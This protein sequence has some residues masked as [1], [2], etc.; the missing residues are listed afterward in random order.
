MSKNVL[1]SEMK[2]HRKVFIE[3]VRTDYDKR[4]VMEKE[5]ISLYK[6]GTEKNQ[7]LWR[8]VFDGVDIMTNLFNFQE[9]LKTFNV[10]GLV[11]FFDFD[12]INTIYDRK[13]R[14][15][16]EIDDYYNIKNEKTKKIL[17]EL[18]EMSGFEF[19]LERTQELSILIEE[20]DS[21]YKRLDISKEDDHLKFILIDES[22]DFNRGFPNMFYMGACGCDVEEIINES[23]SDDE[24][25]E[26]SD[27]V[28]INSKE[29]EL[30][31]DLKS[32][33]PIYQKILDNISIINEH[34]KIKRVEFDILMR[35]IF[36]ERIKETLNFLEINKTYEIEHDS[37]FGTYFN[38]NGKKTIL[39][40]KIDDDNYR[41]Y[42]REN[43]ILNVHPYD[44]D[45]NDT[46][47]QTYFTLRDCV[48]NLIIEE[49][50]T[51]KKNCW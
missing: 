10:D 39:V 49:L 29:E 24:I 14:I 5:L 8:K 47:N 17:S 42:I 25:I 46:D 23:D 1:K 19:V 20:T 21:E 37:K 15:A 36:K 12:K 45:Y 26:E 40:K 32:E 13:V 34:T 43:D 18:S 44:Y 50:E 3:L 4:Q 30:M 38:K 48:S 33:G 27:G 31:S 41:I 16:S 35:Q 6:Q 22:K 11:N 7:K 28:V 51:N 9:E 2:K